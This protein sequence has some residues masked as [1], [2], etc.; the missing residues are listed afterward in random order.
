[1]YDEDGART[2]LSPYAEGLVAVVDG[3]WERYL[4]EGIPRR[5]PTTRAN[6][7]NDHQHDLML[8]HVP[9]ARAT[10]APRADKP[11]YIVNDLTIRLKYLKRLK[12]ANVATSLQVAVTEQLDIDFA[13]FRE[14]VQ[15]VLEGLEIVELPTPE[16]PYVTVGYTLDKTEADVQHVLAVMWE[17]STLHWSIDLR[18]LA[19]G[20]G[21]LPSCVPVTPPGPVPLLPAINAKSGVTDMPKEAPPAPAV[22]S[23]PP[24]PPNR[25][26]SPDG[27]AASS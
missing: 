2:A 17:G 4:A 6:I 18:D 25:D 5:N 1:M 15:L 16:P 24:A 14:P 3:G 11:F 22:A 23:E 12:P 21:E 10:T 9:S 19:K 26:E 20:R 8:T 27:S 7:V 13:E